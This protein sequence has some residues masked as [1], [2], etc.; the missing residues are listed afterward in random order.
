LPVVL[1][2]DSGVYTGAVAFQV[3][4]EPR[5]GQHAVSVFY[6]YLSE[7]LSARANAEAIRAGLGERRGSKF[8][9]VTDPAGGARNPV[10]P[11]VIA[12]YAAAGLRLDGWPLGSIVDGLA[13]VEALVGPPARLSVHPG[14]TRLIEALTNY[15]RAK[16]AGQWQDKPEDPQH[17]YEDMVDALRGGLK[18]EFPEGF[19]A[20]NPAHK[21]RPVRSVFY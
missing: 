18:S 8:R 1:A 14:C 21:L 19:K 5:T 16:R 2:V 13:T 7:G 3:R 11:T 6:D 12:E 10:G 15:R 20:A 9:A 4:H 17:P